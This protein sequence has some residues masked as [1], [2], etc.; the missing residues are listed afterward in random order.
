MR[1]TM[2]LGVCVLASLAACSGETPAD[3]RAPEGPRYDGGWTMGSGGR[4]VGGAEGTSTT[5]SRFDRH[6]QVG[7]ARRVGKLGEPVPAGGY[8][9][10]AA[11]R[12]RVG[13][14]SRTAHGRECPE[15]TSWISA[16]RT[17]GMEVWRSR[18]ACA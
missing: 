10:S 15:F 7:V 4:S 3:V 17:W 8:E 16:L 5:T 2:I 9:R 14:T 12:S 6:R 13:S 18:I 11:S 1:R